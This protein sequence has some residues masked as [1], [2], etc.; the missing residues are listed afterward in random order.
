VARARASND[1][2][3]GTVSFLFT[4]VE[5]STRL[6]SADG[7]AMSA[8]L[9]LHDE[10]LRAA[11]ESADG[12]VFSTAGDSFAAAFRRASDAVAAARRAQD[13]LAAA[14]WPGPTLRVRMG[15]HLGEVEERG[16]DYFGS[17]VNTAARVAAAGHGGQV[18]L[19]DGIRGIADV[20][21]VDL[22]VHRLRDVAE[23]LHI[24]QL[25]EGDFP[26]L[27]VVD[28]RSSNL[29]VRP[30]RIIGRD[31]ELADI[32]GRLA[33]SRLV[34]VTAVGGSGKTRLAIAVG[35]AELL[36]RPGGVW[37]V[38]LTAV[39]GDN[40]VPA[41]IAK[42][43]GLTLHE[44]DLAQQVVEHLADKDALV[45]LDNCEHVVEGCADFADRFLGAP[46]QATLLATSREA[47]AVDGEQ[48]VVLGALPS[49][50]ADS[51]AVRLFADRAF[52]VD[53]HFEVDDANAGTMV[54]LCR[55][56]DGM[57]LAIELAAARVTV[58]TPSE[59][60]AGLNDRFELLSGG[61]RHRQRT[62]EATLDWSYDLLSSDEQQTLLA[63]GVFVDGFDLDAVAAVANVTRRGAVAL[64][65]A[66]VAKSLVI[67]VDK[68]DR[69][70]FGL[71]ETVK[72]YAEDHLR[73][74][75]EVEE[76]RD[77]H[78]DHF[79]ALA[80]VHG[81]TGFS[82]IR[83]GVALRPDRGNLTAAFE[84]AA[85][86]RR[87]VSAGELIAGS[88]SAYLFDGGAIEARDLIDR[89]IAACAV[90]QTELADHLRVG[91][92][93]LVA[94]LNDW[95]TFG[96]AAQVVT[97][98]TIGPLRVVGFVCLAFVTALSDLERA[99]ALLAQAQAEFDDALTTSPGLS[100]GIVT[101]F[102]PWIRARIAGLTGDF[103]AALLGTE[104]FLD[105]SISADY[106]TTAAVRAAKHAAVCRVLLGDPAAAITTI[107]W[108][109]GFD[110]SIFN[111][112]EI[113]A[114]AHLALGDVAEAGALI[115]VQAARALTGRAIGEVCDSALLLAAFAEA[116]GSRDLA[117]QLLLRM[118]IGKEAATVIYSGHLAAQLGI[119]DQHAERQRL[120]LTYD[121]SSPEGPGGTRMAAAAV[122][123]ELA[124]RGWT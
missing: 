21:A 75:G 26:A 10:I 107:E 55:H 17:S 38:D 15:L 98:S 106:Y 103:E 82:E 30:T 5:G 24:F 41:A 56:L 44:G 60:L 49:E 93:L 123:D 35:E 76:V 59:L 108:L 50:G 6:W 70:R 124:R 66:L 25:G 36:K 97:T 86:R 69:A 39:L 19:T 22:G 57:P 121:T 74:A 33:G 31:D 61:R 23:P 84:W 88:W 16:G 42:A 90:D 72:A 20:A 28:P 46:G 113:R 116:E 92:M 89:A 3:S 12:Y 8:S 117:R 78:L 83:L 104:Q 34:T 47:L 79:H 65:E 64:I 102:V 2:P 105:S 115:R 54:A 43:V 110:A 13:G 111:G 100:T 112:D 27:R 80:T 53:P 85:S 101:G 71:L 37:F 87:W 77:R 4:D 120:A 91:L 11:I 58:M 67:R 119:S 9:A 18:L 95:T 14:A 122:R 81:R 51:P 94:W 114:L 1:L 109:E 7:P 99:D 96:S 118:G 32:R 63:L 48:I 45:I 68:G 29:P 52:A 73:A 40:D 62:L